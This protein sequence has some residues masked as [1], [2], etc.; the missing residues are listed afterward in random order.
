MGDFAFTENFSE[1]ESQKLNKK[2]VKMLYLEDYLEMIE[3]LP[4]E[5]RDRFFDMREMDLSVQ[6]R[7]DS[8][9]DRQKTFFGSCRE[10][11]AT[12]REEEFE[13]IRE[14]YKKVVEDANEKV[15]ISEECYSLVDRYLRKLDEEL[16]KFK[17]ELEAD[18]RG[19]TEILEKQS[20]EMDSVPSSTQSTSKENRQPKKNPT[21][22][23][24]KK[25]KKKS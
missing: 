5:L 19:I 25:K 9:A 10:L 15:Q 21:Q 4:S 11:K 7:V 23:K 12:D 20:L 16:L 1:L 14:E 2:F 24:K 17:C 3:H 6:S 13:K 8:L 18:N 22:K